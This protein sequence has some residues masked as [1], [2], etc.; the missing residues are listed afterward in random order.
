MVGRDRWREDLLFL[1]FQV[2][3]GK[4][5]LLGGQGTASQPVTHQDAT[6]IQ[7]RPPRAK[8]ELPARCTARMGHSEF[9]P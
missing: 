5:S 7:P 6:V 1:R 9:N 3:T 4:S 2:A 8:P